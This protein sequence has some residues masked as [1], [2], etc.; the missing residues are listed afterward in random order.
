MTCEAGHDL[1]SGEGREAN[2]VRWYGSHCRVCRA[3]KVHYRRMPDG[4][5]EHEYNATQLNVLFDYTTSELFMAS[6][7]GGGKTFAFVHWGYDR[8]MRNP[9]G[10]RGM[11][12]EPNYGM[13]DR[14]LVPEMQRW[15]QL[16][17]VPW[18]YNERKRLVTLPGNR[19]IWL[20]SADNPDSLLGP[21]LCFFGVDEASQTDDDT[22]K[23][24]NS[25]VRDSR[26]NILQSLFVSTHLGTNTWFNKRAN[27]KDER[28]RIIARQV[29]G[30]SFDNFALPA[31]YFAD[32]LSAYTPGTPEYEMFV[33]GRA[34][35]LSGSIY[36]ALKDRHFRPCTNRADGDVVVMGDFN[37]DYMVSVIGR[38]LPDELH[39]WGEVITKGKGLD[40]AVTNVHYEAVRKYLLKHRVAVMRGS[41]V[42]SV[43]TGRVVEAYVD[44][45]STAQKTSARHSDEWYVKQHG[46]WPM[47]PRGNPPVQSTIDCVQAG[48]KR[49][50][51]FFDERDCPE[52][53]RAMR[54]HDRN[55]K[56]DR[57]RKGREFGEGNVPLDAH[58]D[59]VRYGMWGLMP[60]RDAGFIL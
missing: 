29:S 18:L 60:L 47:H 51:L 45:S 52:T 55:P 16:W 24:G 50:A 7:W 33:N 14:I 28:G 1:V 49:G 42:V 21:T 13:V 19:G 4:R 17:G 37:V 38:W 25:R 11:L 35:S 34:M 40:D 10:S 54:E 5:I 58:T 2:G 9:P 12:V 32:R 36:S 6:G 46:F 15:W 53:C 22:Y 39:I 31:S 8:T 23:A 27:R 3:R 30:R 56:T 41:S 57:P 43:A 20:A 59:C 44:A 26:A 48:L